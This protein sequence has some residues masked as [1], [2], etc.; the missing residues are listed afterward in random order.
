MNNLAVLITCHNRKNKT[1]QCLRNL[2]K[3]TDFINFKTEIFLVD[4]N[5]TDGT[6]ETIK[7][8]L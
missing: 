4:D 3:Q 7:K 8:I 6:S 2:Y 5:S 1:I